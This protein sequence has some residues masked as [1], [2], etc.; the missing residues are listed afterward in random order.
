[1]R[2][3]IAGAT[4]A[5]GRRLLPLLIKDGHAVTGMTRVAG[6]AAAL[7]ALGIAP[8]VVDVFQAEALRE[9]A[10]D[11][12]PEIVIHQLT[13]LPQQVP[14]GPLDAATAA[15][16]ARIRIEG[17]ANLLEAARDAGA[18]RFI[19]QSI[20]FLYAAGRTPHLEADALASAD[21]DAPGALTARGVRALEHATLSTPGIDGIVLRYG[22]LYGP[23]TWFETP[24]GPGSLHVDAAAHA[25]RLAVT[26]GGPGVYNIA[27]DDGEVAIDKARAELGFDPGFRDA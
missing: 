10:M 11:A 27:E 22:R 20:A 14:Q 21:D 1:M 24:R 26:R 15:R 2:V 7:E 13:D 4:G 9:A 18:R 3:L 6:K 8:I 23:G 12:R 16:N 19:A 17:T 25:A 5:I